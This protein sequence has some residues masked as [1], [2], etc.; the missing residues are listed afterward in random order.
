MTRG[1]VSASVYRSPLRH[2]DLYRISY[3]LILHIYSLALVCN[4]IP[5]HTSTARR[6]RTRPYTTINIHIR[7]QQED[8]RTHCVVEMVYRRENVSFSH[9]CN[10]QRLVILR[11]TQL[12]N[13]PQAYLLSWAALFLWYISWS[14]YRT[15]YDI[16]IN[17][18]I[19]R[20]CW[21]DSQCSQTQMTTMLTTINDQSIFL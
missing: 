7:S 13:T 2:L 6:R 19:L 9:V 5:Y 16:A 11:L 12:Q 21:C 8:E 17:W 1:R 18:T 10:G 4:R 15:T 3:H 14:N 20:K